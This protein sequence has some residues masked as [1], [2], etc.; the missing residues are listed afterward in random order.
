MTEKATANLTSPIAIDSGKNHGQR[1]NGKMAQS[2]R[3][4]AVLQEN[5]DSISYAVAHKHHQAGKWYID[6]HA[7]KTHTPT[8]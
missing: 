5:Q 2:L 1:G 3:V 8:E 7:G 4:L 6:M